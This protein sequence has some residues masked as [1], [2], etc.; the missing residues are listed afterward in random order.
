MRISALMT[1]NELMSGDTVDSNSARIAEAIQPMGLTLFEKITLGDDFYRLCHAIKTLAER[2]DIL[3]INGGLGPTDDDLTAAVLAHVCNRP[4]RTND[5]ALSHLQSW[6]ESRGIPNL[7]QANLK[8]TLLPEGCEI[9]PNPVG[10]AVGIHLQ[11]HD[12]T[13]FATP[14]VPS[15]LSAMLRET[16]T[17][18]IKQRLGGNALPQIKRLRL[19][20]MGESTIQQQLTEQIYSDPQYDAWSRMMELG[21]RVQA[22]LVEVKIIPKMVDADL[23]SERDDALQTMADKLHTLFN[24]YIIGFNDDTLQSVLVEQLQKSQKKLVTAESCTGGLIAARITEIPGSSQV[25]EGS[26]VT[27]SNELKSSALNVPTETLNSVGAVSKEVVIA[28]AQNALAQ[29]QADYAIAVS[30]VAGPSGGTPDKP[31]GTVWIAWGDRTNIEAEKLIFKAP[32]KVFQSFI[33]ATALDLIRRK[34]LNILDRPRYLDN[35]R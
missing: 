28:M 6:A 3:M 20:G 2:S 4:L 9:I 1:G 26:W 24:H 29:S 32:R 12:C 33:A 30:G 22:P 16:L 23:V 13:I 14:G 31:V 35:I 25:Y 27:Y 8:Q 19:F 5:N 34:N 18:Y 21:F 15:E 7:N 17:P 10:S 11:W